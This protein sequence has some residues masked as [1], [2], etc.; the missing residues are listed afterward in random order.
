M[1]IYIAI[2]L[3]RYR[4]QAYHQSRST[5]LIDMQTWTKDKIGY[6][7]GIGYANGIGYTGQ[8]ECLLVQG[9][10]WWFGRGS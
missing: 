8:D 4:Y 2:L 10:I 7:D 1:L 6:A 3:I 9:V 5:G